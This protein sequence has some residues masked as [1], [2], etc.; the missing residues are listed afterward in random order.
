M[1]ITICLI[2]VPEGEWRAKGVENVFSEIMVEKFL[3]L[4]KETDPGTGRTESQT[5]WTPKDSH[6]GIKIKTAKVNERNLKTAREKQ[7]VTSKATLIR[8]WETFLQKHCRPEGN[9]MTCLE[10]KGIISARLSFRRERVHQ[11]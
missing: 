5:R 7:G 1:C 11:Y 9:G 6:L 4:K 10:W 3:N 8:L 2:R